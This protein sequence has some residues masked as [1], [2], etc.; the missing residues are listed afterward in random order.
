MGEKNMG[1]GRSYG[2]R[3]SIHVT[4]QIQPSVCCQNLIFFILKKA[5]NGRL[6]SK[7]NNQKKDSL[8][9]LL[10][11]YWNY[12][13]IKLISRT[14][15]GYINFCLKNIHEKICRKK[16][17]IANLAVPNFKLNNVIILKPT[18]D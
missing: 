10:D 9:D 6:E 4:Y 12:I 3:T 15:C 2:G 18:Y 17:I 13:Y 1:V 14:L 8:I 16:I 5:Q 7:R 11:T